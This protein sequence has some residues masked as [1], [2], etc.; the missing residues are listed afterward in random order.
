MGS[1]GVPRAD[2]DHDI[3]LFGATGFTGRLVARAFAASA[4]PLRWALAGRN[5]AALEAVRASLVEAH[6][7]AAGVPIRVADAHD[8]ASLD[9][10]ARSA[11]VVCT[12]VGPYAVHG[13]DLVAACAEAGTDCCDITGEVHWV[14]AMIDAWHDRAVATGAR[15]VPCC[16]FDSVPSDLGVLLLRQHFA[17]TGDPLARARFRLRYMRGGA[18]GGTVASMLALAERWKDPAVRRVLGDPY[19]L[20]PAGSPRGPDRNDAPGPVRDP[21]TGRW[22]GPFVMAGINTRVVRRS[23]SLDGR[24]CGDAFSYQEAVDLGRG[25][26]GWLRAAGLT[27]GMGA[28]LGAAAWKP[29]RRL[30]ARLAPKPGEGPSPKTMAAGGFRIEIQG[31]SASG[32]KASAHVSAA[33]DPGYGATATMLSQAALSLARDDLP[34]RGGLLTPASCMGLHLVERLRA[35]GFVFSVEGGP[36]AP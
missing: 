19:A 16:G 20:D 33:L 7:G 22:T 28:L 23:H 34:P 29:T 1:D 12:T 35:H 3:V 10:V 30:L 11:R 32:R 2:R 9:A 24:P 6:P 27:A 17:E 36:P 31:V 13:S 5:G 15:I 4:E 8:R 21:D 26:G 18:S 25:P 14:R